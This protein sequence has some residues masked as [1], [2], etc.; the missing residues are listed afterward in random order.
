MERLQRDVDTTT[1]VA[2]DLRT[3]IAESG[4]ATVKPRAL[5]RP[6]HSVAGD[7]GGGKPGFS[8]AQELEKRN[9][10]LE[11]FVDEGAPAPMH[12]HSARPPPA[13]SPPR[14]PL[15]GALPGDGRA[16]AART[17]HRLVPAA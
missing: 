6:A 13:L 17:A 2:R 4:G 16:A 8:A 9:L 15:P 1:R 5:P 7:A 3:A 10:D 14:S 12:A 11:K